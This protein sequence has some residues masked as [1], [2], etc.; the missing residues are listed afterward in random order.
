[1][2]L[3]LGEEALCSSDIHCWNPR[4]G[5]ASPVFQN[6]LLPGVREPTRSSVYVFC[7]YSQLLHGTT[8]LNFLC[9][10]SFTSRQNAALNLTSS[11]L[12]PGK[13]LKENSG[14]KINNL[15]VNPQTFILRVYTNW[16]CRSKLCIKRGNWNLNECHK[17]PSGRSP[18]A[19]Q[20]SS[21]PGCGFHLLLC[22]C[23]HF[24]HSQQLVN[25]TISRRTE[26]GPCELR[27]F[28]NPMVLPGTW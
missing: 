6:L 20:L 24:P 27:L 9:F 17:R 2:G 5:F 7:S 1:M 15:T 10:P 8:P 25:M 28:Y 16:L 19:F 23:W 11:C 13:S 3:D 14:M 26:Q 18:T 4:C 21:R 22:G 12:S